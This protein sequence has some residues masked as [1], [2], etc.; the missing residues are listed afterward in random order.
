MEPPPP[1]PELDALVAEFPALLEVVRTSTDDARD[2][3]RQRLI[4]LFEQF[5]ADDARVLRARRDLASALY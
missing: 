3:A 1:D 4:E 2:Q 5:P